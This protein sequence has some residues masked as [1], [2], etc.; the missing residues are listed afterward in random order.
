MLRHKENLDSGLVII[1]FG[2]AGTLQNLHERHSEGTL[3][4]S[5]P[6]LLS[7]SCYKADQGFDVWSLGVLLYKLVFGK[8]PFEGE[9]FNEIKENV[10]NK[11]LSLPIDHEDISDTCLTLISLMLTKDRGRRPKLY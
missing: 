1:D 4:Y 11:P 6:E 8:F 2:I 3:R 7:G 10:I 9:T 5:P